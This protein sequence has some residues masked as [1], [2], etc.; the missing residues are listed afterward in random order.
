MQTMLTAQTVVIDFREAIRAFT[1]I[2][3]TMVKLDELS[4]TIMYFTNGCA[5]QLFIIL[6]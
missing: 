1:V 5:L 6:K 2:L 4:S 3:A